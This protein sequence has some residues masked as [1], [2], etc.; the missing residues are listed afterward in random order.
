MKKYLMLSL[1]L[2]LSLSLVGC[3]NK[4]EEEQNEEV[5]T[6]TYT[7]EN[8][9]EYTFTKNVALDIQKAFKILDEYTWEEL[10]LLADK[11]R[12]LWGPEDEYV[13]IHIGDYAIK[14]I[15]MH[16]GVETVQGFSSVR[17]YY[18]DTENNTVYLYDEENGKYIKINKN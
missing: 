18:I 14:T 15:C 1:V 6:Y 17:T 11:E 7:D 12:Y 4:K 5:E 13:W 2:M 10:N 9:E 16:A 3:E 8:G